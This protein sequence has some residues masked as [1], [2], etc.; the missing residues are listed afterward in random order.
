MSKDKKPLIVDGIN[1]SKCCYIIDYDPPEWQGTWGG[2]IHK[3]ACK[4]YSKDCKDNPNCH[5]KQL[6][7]KT[8]ECEELKEEISKLQL[9]EYHYK[10]ELKKYKKGIH[11][12]RNLLKY[13]INNLRLSRREFLKM[14]GRYPKFEKDNIKLALDT[15]NKKLELI[16]NPSRYHKALEEIEKATKINCEEICGRKFEDCNDTSCFS[17]EL[18]G[19]VNKAK[20]RNN[21]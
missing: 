16:D 17:A 15:F 6:A 3:G 12:Y 2:A 7:R 21:E 9:N 1:V 11:K 10:N 18:L 13:E 4:V 5:F 20:G 19:I 14:V 8:Q